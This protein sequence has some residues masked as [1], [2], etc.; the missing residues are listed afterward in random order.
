MSKSNF[1]VILLAT[2][3]ALSSCESKNHNAIVDKENLLSEEFAEID[4]YV[5]SAPDTIATFPSAMPVG[6]KCAD[7]SLYVVFDRQDTLVCAY[8]LNDKKHLGVVAVRG[9]GPEELL[10]PAFLHNPVYEE[11]SVVR[12]HDTNGFQLAEVDVDR[13]TITKYSLPFEARNATSMNFD[14]HRYVYRPISESECFFMIDDIDKGEATKVAYPFELSGQLKDMI[15]GREAYL[16]SPNLNVNYRKGRI[17]ASM[18]FSDAY[19]VYDTEGKLISEFSPSGASLDINEAFNRYFALD[20]GAMARYAPGYAT[21]DFCYLR[22]LIEVPNAGRDDYQ[23]D[24][25]AILMVDWDGKPRSL[26]HTPDNMQSFC[27]D[28]SGRIIAIVVDSSDLN[29]SYHIIRYGDMRGENQA[30]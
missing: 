17:I 6:L 29:E 25:T 28:K 11:E 21:D 22:R 23:I 26:I 7:T 24:K 5:P 12:I 3:L 9:N 19:Y 27:V 14:G 1:N 20:N 4:H 30:Q 15:K 13:L 16:L 2:V 18:Y 10:S 8:S